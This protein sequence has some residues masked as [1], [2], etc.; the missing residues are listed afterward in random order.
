M[1][2]NRQT[3]SLSTLLGSVIDLYQ[4]VAEE[5]RISLTTNFATPV[6]R[7]SM[8]YECARSSLIYWTTR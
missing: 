6:M 5:K 3:T 1:R 4:L 7:R 2:L 8:P